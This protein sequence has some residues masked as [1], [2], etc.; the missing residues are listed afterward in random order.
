MGG[1]AMRSSTAILAFSL[2]LF[3]STSS[4]QVSVFGGNHARECFIEAISNGANTRPC[5]DSIGSKT[6]LGRDLAAT[7]VNRAVVRT[8]AGKFEGALKDLKRAESIRPDFGEIYASRGNVHYY[9]ND[10]DEA[11]AQYDRSIEKGMKHLHAAHYDRGLALEQ[12]GRDEEAKDA[13]RQAIA[14]KPEFELAKA[15]LALQ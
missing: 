3:A 2:L 1:D 8:N 10:F 4:A 9:Q 15:R 5:D 14:I 13:Y 6:L 11:L 7:Y 12:L